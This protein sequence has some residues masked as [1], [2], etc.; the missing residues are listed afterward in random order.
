MQPLVSL[1]SFLSQLPIDPR[2]ALG[3]WQS[4]KTP[5]DLATLAVSS[6]TFP[7]LLSSRPGETRRSRVTHSSF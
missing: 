3:P 6:F 1:V 2:K 5:D 4:W 7:S